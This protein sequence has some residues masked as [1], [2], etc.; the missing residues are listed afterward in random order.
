MANNAAKIRELNT[1]LDAGVNSLTL[2]NGQ[3]VNYNLAEVR[4]RRDELIAAD[5]NQKSNR[6]ALAFINLGGASA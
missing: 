6:P 5:D 4:K 2:P 3:T 1:I